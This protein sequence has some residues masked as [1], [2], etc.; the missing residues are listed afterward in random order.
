MVLR[1]SSSSTDRPPRVQIVLLAYSFYTSSFLY[2]LSVSCS[3][4]N[5]VEEGTT[6][7]YGSCDVMIFYFYLLV[8][9]YC[10]S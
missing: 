6:L 2:Q 5:G 10:C 8:V 4:L 1:S 9:S 7:L 3:V